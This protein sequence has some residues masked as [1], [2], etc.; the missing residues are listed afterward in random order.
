M[1]TNEAIYLGVVLFCFAAFC[2]TLAWGVAFTKKTKHQ[3]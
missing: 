1:S 3:H 2:G